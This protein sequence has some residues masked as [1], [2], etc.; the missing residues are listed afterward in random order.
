MRRKDPQKPVFS[1]RLRLVLLVAAELVVSILLAASLIS[2]LDAYLFVDWDM[3]LL[4]MLICISLLVGILVTG[5][6]SRLFFEPVKKLRQAMKRVAEGDFTVKLENKS[7]SKEIQEIYNG[8]NLMTHELHSTEILQ[9]NFVANVSHE[10]KTPISAI[11]GYS[12][13]LQDCENLT[14]QQQEYVNKIVLNTRRL[15]SLAGSVLLL[16]KLENQQIPTNQSRYSLDEQI[17]L[18]IVS[19]E[20]EWEKK[21]IEFD[22]QMDRLDYFGSQGL[23][24]H[25]WSNLLSNA[26]KFSPQEG[27]IKLRLKALGDQLCFVV[28]DAGPGIPQESLQHI[29][30]KFYQAD[31][32]HKQ[33]GNGL[34]LSLVKE[35]L[36]L[37]KGSVTAENLP[38][39]GCRFTVILENRN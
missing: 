25:V 9:S 19:L 18:T 4:W 8:F 15:S 39:G 11:E 32:S 13:L 26:I 16:S 17:L 31:S 29:F 12:M 27:V 37:E 5:F 36:Q 38:Q 34:G 33:E 23:M 6:L 24:G 35:I 22:V 1:L 14:A 2:L 10:F 21:K 3:T 30:E 7:S 28:E 20:P